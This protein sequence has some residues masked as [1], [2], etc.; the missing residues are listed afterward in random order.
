[1]FPSIPIFLKFTSSGN[2]L[3]T[4]PQPTNQDD[5]V[6]A[7][8][9]RK[10]SS[11]PRAFVHQRAVPSDNRPRKR[12]PPTPKNRL[13]AP[14]DLNL[15]DS[16]RNQQM[17]LQGLGELYNIFLLIDF[18]WITALGAVYCIVRYYLLYF[19]LSKRFLIW[20]PCPLSASR[21][22]FHPDRLHLSQSTYFI[23]IDLFHPNQLLSP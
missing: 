2:F 1:M 22:F 19:P 6:E 16:L 10:C 21:S 5:F 8:R 7:H 14:S 4:P 3:R 20:I 15:V 12:S 11:H 13:R 23:P 9:R 17:T 18:V